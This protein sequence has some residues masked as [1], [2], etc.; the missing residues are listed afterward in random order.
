MDVGE[1]L[2]V[3]LA[4]VEGEKAFTALGKLARINFH[5]DL[6]ACRSGRV[7]EQV[8]VFSLHLASQAFDDLAVPVEIEISQLG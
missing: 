4:V 3:I 2:F 6:E 1:S 8:L 7:A 5:A